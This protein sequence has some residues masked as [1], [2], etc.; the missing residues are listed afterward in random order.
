MDPTP[1][2]IVVSEVEE[3]EKVDA[4]PGMAVVPEAAALEAELLVPILDE[5]DDST[6]GVPTI[7]IS[8]GS[9]DPLSNV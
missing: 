6:G 4:T 9:D 1:G 5:A 3:V 8:D 2:I 7:V